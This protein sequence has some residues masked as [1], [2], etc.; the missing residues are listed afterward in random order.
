VKVAITSRTVLARRGHRWPAQDRPRHRAQHRR[1]RLL[2]E[3]PLAGADGLADELQVAIDRVALV[4][5]ALVHGA[6]NRSRPASNG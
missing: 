5:E 3:E 2:H 6:R 1:Q 4:G